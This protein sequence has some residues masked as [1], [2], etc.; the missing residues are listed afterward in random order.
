MMLLVLQRPEDRH[1]FESQSFQRSLP[2]RPVPWEEAGHQVPSKDR[3]P[4]TG[5]GP[6][7]LRYWF[8]ARQDDLIIFDLLG[9]G[10]GSVGRAVTH[11]RSAV[12][13]QSLAKFML[14]ICFVSTELKRRK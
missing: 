3:D 11:L 9:S 7:L 6:V 10:C 12:R 14:Y 8:T 1:Q 13:I 2:E 4:A 5:Q